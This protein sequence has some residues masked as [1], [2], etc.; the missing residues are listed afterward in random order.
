MPCWYFDKDE[1]LQSASLD[2]GITTE[3]ETKYRKDGA[4]FIVEI[5]NQLKLYL[6]FIVV[7]CFWHVL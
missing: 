1:L 3:T 4:G 5:S 6:L 2:V 7:E